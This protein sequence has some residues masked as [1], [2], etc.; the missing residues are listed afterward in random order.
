MDKLEILKKVLEIGQSKG[1][2]AALKF[3]ETNSEKSKKECLEKIE[4]LFKQ[5]DFQFCTTQISYVN[6]KCKHQGPGF[7]CS[8]KELKT[9]VGIGAITHNRLKNFSKYFGVKWNR[10]YVIE[11]EQSNSYGRTTGTAHSVCIVG[12][13]GKHTIEYKRKETRSPGAGQTHLFID[14]QNCCYATATD[15]FIQMLAI[16]RKKAK[17]YKSFPKD[18]LTI[19]LENYKGL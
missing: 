4:S 8:Y 3:Y 17:S 11:V 19:L 13:I 5:N 2:K 9:E 6:N 10:A 14:G 16:D 7:I 12:K 15:E 1:K 18:I